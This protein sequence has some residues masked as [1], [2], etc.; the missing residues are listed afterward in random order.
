MNTA[1]RIKRAIVVLIVSLLPIPCFRQVFAYTPGA[2]IR[3]TPHDFSTAGQ[4]TTTVGACTF[5][6]TPHKSYQTR[7]L[8]NHTHPATNYTWGNYTVTSGGTPLPTIQSGWQGPTVFCLSCH[9]GTVARGD[10]AWY[11]ER[12]W[13]G[14]NAINKDTVRI[15]SVSNPFSIQ[16]FLRGMIGND[17]P[18]AAP[19]PYLQARNTYNGVTTGAGVALA[20]Y[21]SNPTTSGIRL[22]SNPASLQVLAGP[23]AGRTGIECTSCHGTHNEPGMVVDTPFLRGKRSGGTDGIC[24]KCHIGF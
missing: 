3:D 4:N 11:K 17:H 20:K 12:S 24:Y 13:T 16:E 5:C 14:A 8:W 10:I 6:H 2:G 1:I 23:N 21:V 9:D 18:V 15:G 22:F 19:Y 7:L